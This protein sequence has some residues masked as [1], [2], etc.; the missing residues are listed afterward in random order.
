MTREVKL[1]VN[2]QPVELDYFVQGF[3]DHTTGGVLAGLEGVR[4]I[5]SVTVSIEGDEITINLNN[6]LLQIN[7]FVSKIIKNTIVGMVSSLK[8]VSNV[9]RVKMSIKR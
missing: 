6:A 1:L 7:P 3:I 5:G 2:D 9:D 4:R 8:G